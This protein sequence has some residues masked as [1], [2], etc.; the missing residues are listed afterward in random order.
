MELRAITG[1]LDPNGVDLDPELQGRIPPNDLGAEASLVV[2]SLLDGVAR[3]RALGLVR[4]QHF[5]H[6]AFRAVFEAVAAMHAAGEAID[7]ATVAT[8]LRE[9][10]RYN[11]LGPGGIAEL[12]VDAP[13]AGNVAAYARAIVDAW[14]MRE[15][16]KHFQ[17]WRVEAYGTR[18]STPDAPMALAQ[19]LLERIE[20]TAGDLASATP[21]FTAQTGAEVIADAQAY[22][23]AQGQRA[24][25]RH[26]AGL[27]TGLDALDRFTTGLHAPDLVLLGALPSMGK[28]ALLSH[29]AVAAAQAGIGVAFFSLEMATRDVALRA[30]CARAGCSMTEVRS[31]AYLPADRARALAMAM[32]DIARLPIVWDGLS[33]KNAAATVPTVVD[34]LAKAER[35]ASDARVRRTPPIGLVIVD[36]LQRV[37]P[38]PSKLSRTREEAVAETAKGLKLLAVRLGV[39]VLCAAALNRQSA[40]EGRKPEMRD[41]RESGSAEYEADG[42]WLLHRDDYKFERGRP[43]SHVFNREAE[44]IVA[45]A[46]NGATG[47]VAVRFEREFTRFSDFA[48]EYEGGPGPGLWGAPA[49]AERN[50]G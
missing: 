9:T 5:F 22:L 34:L 15:L 18:R 19:E 43:G 14:R 42:V 8:R 36:Y 31:G 46:R 29:V 1:G 48:D 20:R 32:N 40:A 23:E 30:A 13:A 38:L 2:T 45:K 7:V 41:L 44:V 6:R 21:T 37:R 16:L 28:S 3:A 33:T 47:S 17:A 10:G 12:L 50:D 24:A 11:E 26:V 39:P 4:P 25:E 49:A 35:A 27:T